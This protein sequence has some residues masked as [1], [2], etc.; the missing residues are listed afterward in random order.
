MT[1]PHFKY[2]FSLSKKIHETGYVFYCVIKMGE[3]CV[4]NFQEV[5]LKFPL[6]TLAKVKVN[7]IVVPESFVVL[8]RKFV[9][10]CCWVVADTVDRV[11][12]F[13]A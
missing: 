13:T 3:S 12:I 5:F 6:S 2:R 9:F 11:L 8:N 10:S 7:R 4:H 1:L